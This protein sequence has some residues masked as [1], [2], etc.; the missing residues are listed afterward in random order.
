MCF[1]WIGG[2]SLLV[3]TCIV[4]LHTANTGCTTAMFSIESESESY[5]FT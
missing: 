5:K 1:S 4:G 2:G 3:E